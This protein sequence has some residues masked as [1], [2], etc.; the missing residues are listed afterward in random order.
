MEVSPQNLSSVVGELRQ[1]R[2][3]GESVARTAACS[4]DDEEVGLL[5]TP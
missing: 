2:V 1:P 3:A 5:M 4:S